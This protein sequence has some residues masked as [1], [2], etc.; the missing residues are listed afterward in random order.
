MIYLLILVTFFSV[1]L[2]SWGGF[3]AFSPSV[4]TLR[5]IIPSAGKRSQGKIFSF[6]LSP[7]I[8]LSKFFLNKEG[9]KKRIGKNLNAAKVGINLEQFLGVKIFF[10]VIFPVVAY[11]LTGKFSPFLIVFVLLGYLLPDFY[12]KRKITAYKKTIA[13]ILPETIDIIGLCIEAGLDFVT[14]VRWTI[15]KVTSNYFLQELGFTLEEINWGKPRVEALKDMSKRLGIPEVSSFVQTLVQA[16]KMGSPVAEAFAILSED[17]REQRYYKGEEKA[18]KAPI[19]MLFPLIFC[20]LPV[21][22]II[23]GGPIILQFMKGGLFKG[24]MGF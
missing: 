24:G 1:A 13:E 9:V 4:Y 22:G 3:L 23:I 12:I 16:E 7:F 21:I 11:F 5:G 2:V 18:L 17:A 19:K 20:I 10:M 6:L 14:A 8:F 15:E